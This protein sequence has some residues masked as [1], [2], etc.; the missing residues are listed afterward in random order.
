M[1]TVAVEERESTDEK[2]VR[3]RAVAKARGWRGGLK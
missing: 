1:K 3:F 2:M